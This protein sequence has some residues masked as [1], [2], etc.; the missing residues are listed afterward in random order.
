MKIKKDILFFEIIGIFLVF[1]Q[2]SR[3]VYSTN[4]RTESLPD[5][6]YMLDYTK[7]ACGTLC[8]SFVDQYYGGKKL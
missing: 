4:D 7:S 3:V 5:N 8:L 6:P 1:S 2:L